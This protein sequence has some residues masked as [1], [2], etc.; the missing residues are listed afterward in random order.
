MYEI[1]YIYLLFQIWIE[2]I[3]APMLILRFLQDSDSSSEQK[4]SSSVKFRDDS[5]T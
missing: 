2:E 1:V 5:H 4:N 3:K